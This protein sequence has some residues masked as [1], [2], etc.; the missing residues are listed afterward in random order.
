MAEAI[1][2]C[3]S[4]ALMD[5]LHALAERRYAHLVELQQ[6]GRWTRYYSKEDFALQ[7]TDASHLAEQWQRICE[8]GSRIAAAGDG[9]VGASEHAVSAGATVVVVSLPRAVVSAA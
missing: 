6:S 4:A 1:P 3:M 7:M 8:T 2:R 9:T 5:K